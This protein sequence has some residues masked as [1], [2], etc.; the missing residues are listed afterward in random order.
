MQDQLSLF[1][2]KDRT[3]EERDTAANLPSDV[4]ALDEMFAV[5]ERLRDSGTYR[6]M[7][8][9]ISR[10]PQYS[11]FNG[12]LMF[13][14]NPKARFVATAGAW[15]RRFGRKPR[16]DA[17]PLM[18]LAPMAP[19]LFLYDIEETSGPPIAA[20]VLKPAAVTNRQL[21]EIYEKTVENCSVHG[22]A[23]RYVDTA[24]PRLGQ[25]AVLTVQTRALYR[26]LAPEGRDNY[27][28]LL[29]NQ[30]SLVARYGALARQL[31]QIFCGHLG[32]D[33]SAWW[34]DRRGT[35]PVGAR[36]EAASVAYLV[37]C[38][39]MLLEPGKAQ[40]ADAIRPDGILPVFGLNALFQSAQYIEDM[41]KSLWQFPRKKSR[42]L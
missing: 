11:A 17:R 2:S 30:E 28:V 12:C 22:I 3:P 13:I 20:D 14:Q 35:A 27:L 19:V 5:G 16:P 26:D 25:V 18:I 6:G 1:P 23:V 29:G 40:V 42:Y 32:I 37:L 31:G 15:E 7:L 8:R 39:R 41:G 10:F 36:I 34:P 21:K 4:C 24:D 38:R 9:F 33:A